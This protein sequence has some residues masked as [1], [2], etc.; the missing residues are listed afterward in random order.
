MSF[1]DPSLINA[2]SQLKKSLYFEY[3]LLCVLK[4]CN[5]FPTV[6]TANSHHKKIL[7]SNSFHLGFVQ[8]D[9]TPTGRMVPEKKVFTSFPPPCPL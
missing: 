5:F 3:F 2:R 7:L 9:Q 4:R 6:D 1:H 8:N